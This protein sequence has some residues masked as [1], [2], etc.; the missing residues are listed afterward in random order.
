L[1][2]RRAGTPRTPAVRTAFPASNQARVYPED[3]EG[4]S[5]F[6]AAGFW[7]G[8]SKQSEIRIDEART[9][10]E[11]LQ[12]AP[13]FS[14]ENDGPPTSL[15]GRR[16]ADGGLMPFDMDV[17]V[18][19]GSVATSGVK[20]NIQLGI[21]DMASGTVVS[22]TGV[23]VVEESKTVAADVMDS[24]TIMENI[25]TERVP[26]P[27]LCGAT[28]GMGAG[29]LVVFHNGEVKKMWNWYQRSD[30]LRLT[31]VLGIQA[32][33]P[34]ADSDNFKGVKTSSATRTSNPLSP[35]VEESAKQSQPDIHSGPRT[36]KELVNMM[37]TAKEVSFP[38]HWGQQSNSILTLNRCGI[39]TMG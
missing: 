26:C 10:L 15:A 7:G 33:N 6:D 31:G 37:A 27:R 17:P 16:D 32:D 25:E 13:L 5:F 4:S 22:S 30:T 23:G 21:T 11:Q 36:L 24:T 28:F 2:P 12:P 29:G 9:R 1:S 35:R 18:A 19:Y 14:P 3:R 8:T 38:V 20:H 39:G 34:G